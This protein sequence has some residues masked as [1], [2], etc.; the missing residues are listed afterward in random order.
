[1]D[2]VDPSTFTELAERLPLA[3]TGLIVISKSGTTAGR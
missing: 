2:N 1:M 3:R